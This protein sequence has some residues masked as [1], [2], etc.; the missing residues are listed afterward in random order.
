MADHPLLQQDRLIRGERIS[1]RWGILVYRN[2]RFTQRDTGKESLGALQRRN[3]EE[4]MGLLV[5]LSSHPE[6]NG[7]RG[8]LGWGGRRKNYRSE[9]KCEDAGLAAPRYLSSTIHKD[10]QKSRFHVLLKS[11]SQVA[12]LRHQLFGILSREPFRDQG[13]GPKFITR[14]SA[15]SFIPAWLAQT[16]VDRTAGPRKK[17]E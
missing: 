2:T 16:L 14:P 9:V 11:A 17:C 8:S 1:A 7:N 5:M 3:D 15:P 6:T 10:H 12:G 4:R 13:R